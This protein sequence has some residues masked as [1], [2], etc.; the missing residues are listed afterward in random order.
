MS[1][2]TVLF[3]ESKAGNTKYCKILPWKLIMRNR[4]YPMK[5]GVGGEE[6]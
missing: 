1:K 3:Y 2:I 5:D 6:V 4:V